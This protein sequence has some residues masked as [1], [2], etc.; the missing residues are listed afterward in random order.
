MPCVGLGY[1]WSC[2]ITSLPAVYVHKLGIT[3]M[4]YVNSEVM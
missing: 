2:T 1:S 3:D 4:D